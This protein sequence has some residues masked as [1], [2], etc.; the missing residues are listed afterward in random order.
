MRGSFL[1]VSSIL[2]A[3]DRQ[4]IRRLTRAAKNVFNHEPKKLLNEVASKSS[5]QA[6]R[7]TE[8]Q[9]NFLIIIWNSANPKHHK[10]NES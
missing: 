5:R 2:T 4:P 8:D 1:V 10:D 7:A 3:A 9:R 6:N